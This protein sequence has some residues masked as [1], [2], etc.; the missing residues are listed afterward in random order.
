M[1]DNRLYFHV[2]QLLTV[3]RHVLM[4]AHVSIVFVSAQMDIM[5]LIV[6]KEVSI[7]SL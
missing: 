3:I 5:A 2:F 4:V 7:Q 6:N 1:L